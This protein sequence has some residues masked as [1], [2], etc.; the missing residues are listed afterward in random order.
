VEGGVC[1]GG[2]GGWV[3]GGRGGGGGGGHMDI[4]FDNGYSNA[5]QHQHFVCCDVAGLL[6]G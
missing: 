1:V 5:Y 6:L 2:G 4:K 3:G